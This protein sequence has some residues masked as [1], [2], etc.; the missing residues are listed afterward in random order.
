MNTSNTTNPTVLLTR[1][2][3]ANRWQVSEMT[4]FRRER[5]GIIRPIRHGRIVRFRLDDIEQIEANLR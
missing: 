3:L 2:Q 4:L 5:N 1:R